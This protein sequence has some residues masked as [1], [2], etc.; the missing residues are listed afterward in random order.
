MT[1]AAWSQTNG[2]NA[3]KAAGSGEEKKASY[4][5]CEKMSCMK[6]EKV[7]DTKASATDPDKAAGT[8]TKTAHHCCEG[9]K[10]AKCDMSASD[11]KDGQCCLH[12]G[13]AKSQD[14]AGCCDGSANGCCSKMDD[15]TKEAAMQCCG[16]GKCDRHA[17]WHTGGSL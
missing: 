9:M 8:E 11:R 7:E 1:V 6:H 12:T 13:D 15:K 14:K 5:C 3:T 4:A 17:H 10:D 2:Q 16:A